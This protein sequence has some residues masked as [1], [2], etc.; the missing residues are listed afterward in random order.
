MNDTDAGLLEGPEMDALRELR[1]DV[2]GP[3]QAQQ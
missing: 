3:T 1:A 2:D